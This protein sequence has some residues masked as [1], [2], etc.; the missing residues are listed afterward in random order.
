MSGT[1]N[2]SVVERAFQLARDGKCHNMDELRATLKA[3][4]YESIDNHLAG[5]SIRR[6]LQVLLKASHS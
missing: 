1:G 2:P 3:E 6:Q 4:R 5:P